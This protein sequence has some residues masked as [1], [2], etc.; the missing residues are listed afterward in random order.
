MPGGRLA[1]VVINKD[2]NTD[3]DVTIA[4]DRSLHH[5]AAIRLTGLALDQAD[6]VTLAGASV[7]ADGRWQP[8]EVEALRVAGGSC[9]VHVPAAS[10]VIVTWSA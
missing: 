6:G 4:A 5:A 1:V 10:A 3:A 8:K 7:A 9:E 2:A